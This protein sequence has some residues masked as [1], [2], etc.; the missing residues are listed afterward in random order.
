MIASAASG[1]DRRQHDEQQR[2]AD[3]VEGPLDR[4]VDALE[5]RRLELEQRQR[6]AGDELD[7][8]HQDLHRRRRD[9]HPH[10]VLVALVDQ[11]HGLGLGEVGVGDQHLVDRVEV[12]LELLERAEVAQAVEQRDGRARDEAV[13]L[14]LP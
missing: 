2:R 11:L 8:V 5:D 13:G 3:E 7:A 6:L 9:P 12:A 4:E 10:A 14:D 1:H